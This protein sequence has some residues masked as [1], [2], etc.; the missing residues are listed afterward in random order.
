[1]DHFL[2]AK[3]AKKLDCWSSEKLSMVGK[4]IISNFVMLSTFWSS[5]LPKVAPTKFLGKFGV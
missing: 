4:L 1:M 3:I 2:Y 5:L